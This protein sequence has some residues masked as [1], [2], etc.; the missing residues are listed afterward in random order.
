MHHVLIIL[1]LTFIWG[2]T[3]LNHKNNSFIVS[4][5]IQAMPIKFCCENS[6][7]KGL[8]DHCQ[9]DDLDLHSR[10]QVHLIIMSL[11]L[12]K[13]FEWSGHVCLSF[14]LGN[15]L[16]NYLACCLRKQNLCYRSINKQSVFPFVKTHTHTHSFL[17][18]NTHTHS[19]L[20]E[21]THTHTHTH[22]RTH[23]H[24]A[25]TKQHYF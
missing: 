11:S 9:S 20:C 13:T 10:S 23:T 12:P 3:D 24:T 22:T 19:S 4:D 7:T 14:T 17:C 5:T 8:Y 2:H 15:T 1:T 18:E 21:N 6:P 25:K 16:S